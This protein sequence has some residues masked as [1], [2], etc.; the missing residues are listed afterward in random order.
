MQA[1]AGRVKPRCPLLVCVDAF[2]GGTVIP[3]VWQRDYAKA[4]SELG[5][6]VEVRE[7]PNDDHFS[8]PFSVRD[9]VADWI[10][11]AFIE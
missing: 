4:V 3:V 10:R 5:A 7:F 9:T 2:E 11:K 8:L 1:S 6:K